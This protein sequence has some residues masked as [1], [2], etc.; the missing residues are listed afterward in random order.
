MTPCPRSPRTRPTSAPRAQVGSA[1]TVTL[2]IDGSAVT[3]PA[4]TSVMRAARLAASRSPSCAPPTASKPSAPAAC[5]WSRSRAARAPGLVHH[6]G[7][8]RHGGAHADAALAKLRRGVMELYISDHP[9]D[10]LTCAPTATASCRTWPARSACARCATATTATTTSTCRR[11]KDE[12]NPYFT[13]DPSK[14]IVCSRCVRACEEVQGTFALTID[15][16]GFD[17]RVSP[18]PGEISSTR[19]ACPAAPAC[20]PARP[21]R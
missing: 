15:G 2:T 8:P 18:G 6:A 5:A 19:S 21:R 1:A 4:G 14:C 16:R 9:L 3:V 7:E 12:A 13:F 17:S 20:R 10:C 11:T